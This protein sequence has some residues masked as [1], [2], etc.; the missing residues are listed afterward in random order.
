MDPKDALHIDTPEKIAKVLERYPA[1]E[2][3][4]R[5]KRRSR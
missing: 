3:A 1:H 4:T 2:H 5:I